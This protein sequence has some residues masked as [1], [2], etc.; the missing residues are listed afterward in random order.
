LTY[1]LYSTLSSYSAQNEQFHTFTG[2]DGIDY[3]PLVVFAVVLRTGLGFFDRG[4]TMGAKDEGE[5]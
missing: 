4:S 5:E 2:E 3:R 1:Q